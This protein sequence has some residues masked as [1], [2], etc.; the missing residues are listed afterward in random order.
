MSTRVPHWSVDQ[1]KVAY[2]S[3]R[4]QAAHA[5]R[6]AT[7]RALVALYHQR[8]LVPRRDQAGPAARAALAAVEEMRGSTFSLIREV[9]DAARPQICNPPS[10]RAQPVGETFRVQRGSVLMG[11]FLQGVF[12]ASDMDRLATRAWGTSTACTVGAILWEVCRD[13]AIRGRWWNPHHL[14]WDEGDEKDPVELHAAEGVS[15]RQLLA[16]YPEHASDILAAPLWKTTDEARIRWNATVYDRREVVHSWCLPVGKTPGRYIKRCGKAILEGRKWELPRLPFAFIRW[17]DDWNTT[18]GTPLAQLLLGHQTWDNKL[19]RIMVEASRAAVPRIIEHE[20]AES[21]ITGDTPL[22]KVLYRGQIAPKIE[23]PQVIP[24]DL[25]VLRQMIRENAF[26]LAGVNQGAAAGMRPNGVNSA[27]AQREWREFVSQRL[28]DQIRRFEALYQDSARIVLMLAEDAYKNRDAVV[29]APGTRLLREVR[30]KDIGL[31]ESE[32][33][34]LVTTSSALPQSVAGR[35]EFVAEALKLVDQAGKPLINARDGLSMLRLPDTESM[36]DNATAPVDLAKRQVESALVDGV[37]IPP[38]PVQPLDDLYE[39]ASR[40]LMR[41]QVNESWPEENLELCR[42]LVA[43]TKMLIAKRDG[44]AAPAPT[45][46]QAA[47][48]ETA[49]PTQGAAPAA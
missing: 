7:E 6:V 40:E 16:D 3:E 26:G 12:H 19:V 25:P 23:A 15:E 27:P 47:A 13:S 29:R 32:I 36:T 1:E 45:S 22:A 33:S 18:A 39:Y 41:A 20:L 24:P 38:D 8:P 48:T 46:Q 10:V 37:Y 44:A 11:R 35:L 4:F 2:W 21:T 31:K 49:A 9:I 17:Q 5:A 14:W 42:R 34:L 30:W 43:H 28:S